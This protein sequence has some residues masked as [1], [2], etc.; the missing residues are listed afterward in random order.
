MLAAAASRAQQIPARAGLVLD[1]SHL[2]TDRRYDKEFIVTVISADTNE[3]V[4]QAYF[5]DEVAKGRHLFPDT[6]SRREWLGA[7]AV[8]VGA[9]ANQI[10]RIR[11]RTIMAL[12]KRVYQQLKQTGRM[13]DV[14][15]YIIVGD[16]DAIYRVQGSQQL[17]ATETLTVVID[18]QP[19]TVQALHTRGKFARY[20]P[21]I[22]QVEAENWYLDDSLYAWVLKIEQVIDG[23]PYH[24]RLGTAS[25][26]PPDAGKALDAAL[27][28]ACKADMYGIYFA[29]NSAAITPLS[30]PTLGQVAAVLKAHGDWTLTIQGHTDSIGG[31]KYNQELSARRAAAVKTRLVEHYGVAA[32]RLKTDGVGLARPL[33]PNTTLEG[34]ARNRRVELVR[35]CAGK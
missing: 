17:V 34:R 1:Y 24:V 13:D 2:Q 3:T 29:Y 19:R 23:K 8:G 26:S 5:L 33:A 12:S 20:V 21:P 32:A 35:P 11:N 30:E 31:A 22:I 15:T 7:R 18:G 9:G 16:A 14:A 4:F 25:T 27:A 10:E 28:G 6:V